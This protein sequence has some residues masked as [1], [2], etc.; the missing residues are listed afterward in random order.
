MKNILQGLIGKN[1]Y[2]IYSLGNSEYHYEMGRISY[3]HELIMHL[4]D[5]KNYIR[6]I[7]EP[8]FIFEFNHNLATL[9]VE[10]YIETISIYS[11]EPKSSNI[12]IINS[13]KLFSISVYGF[14][15]YDYADLHQFFNIEKKTTANFLLFI[16]EDETMLYFDTS[17]EIASITL[18]SSEGEVNHRIEHLGLIED[19]TL[20]EESDR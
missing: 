20:I 10:N 1:I 15:F 14:P 7:I 17:Q 11:N 13:K 12:C 2:S 16:F 3:R 9:F 4:K 6:F 8:L 18:F 5:R 19:Y